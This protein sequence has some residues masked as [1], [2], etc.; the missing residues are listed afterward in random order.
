MGVFSVDCTQCG[1]PLLSAN[2]TNDVN[3]WMNQAVVLFPDGDRVSGPYDGYGRVGDL[4]DVVGLEDVDAQHMACWRAAG[5]PGYVGPS[6]HSDDQ[7]W[8]FKDGAHDMLEPAPV[9]A[10]VVS[11]VVDPVV[12]V[13]RERLVA[14]RAL[15]R[16]GAEDTAVDDELT[17]IIEGR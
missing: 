12:I 4:E 1:H 9:P 8:F 11:Q 3:R 14:L 2:V 5:E 16:R 13:N 7:G 17:A 15:L 6:R 10:P